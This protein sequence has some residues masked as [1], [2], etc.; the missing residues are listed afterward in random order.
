MLFRS[1]HPL[2]E[3]L[4]FLADREQFLDVLDWIAAGRESAIAQLPRAHEGRI[5]EISGKIQVY[6]EILNLCDYQNL[7]MRRA[8][9]QSQGLPS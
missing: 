1:K 7:L 2:D 8:V 3:Q 6:D 4:K 5:R 9:R